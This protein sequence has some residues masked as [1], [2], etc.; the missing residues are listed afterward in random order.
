MRILFWSELF[1]PYIGGAEIWGM[2]FLRRL[3]Q[4]GHEVTVITSHDG[5]KLPD[6]TSYDGI[7]IYRFPFRKILRTG[8]LQQFRVTR[9]Q[10]ASLKRLVKPDLIH[11]NAVSASA[12]FHLQTA[13]ADRGSPWLIRI[14]QEIL[15]AD[16]TA[17]N[18]LLRRVLSTADWVTCVSAML[19]EQ[20]RKRA[21]EIVRRSSVIYSGLTVSCEGPRPLN[22]NQGALLCLG[23]LVPAKGFDL[24]L[25]ALAVAVRRFPRLRLIIAGDGPARLNLERRAVEL[26]LSKSVEFVGWVGPD[27]V[28][29]LLSNTSVVLM[30]SRR[31]GLPV[32]AIQAALAGK[33]IVAARVSGLPEA[34]IPGE[35]G[36]LIEKEDAQALAD[37]I[38]Y[39][40]ER[41][42][43]IVRMGQATRRRA[44]ELFS[45]EKCVDAYDALYRKLRER[46]THATTP[47]ST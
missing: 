29:N 45:E 41:P 24:A 31:E 9:Q 34:V 10:V 12:L 39:L 40:A 8:D 21:P 27:L 1:R 33:P 6:E 17:P 25:D 42:E 35:T 18:T 16:G 44:Q 36:L 32:V 11:V 20:V 23:R 46:N 14:N 4:R 15:S 37:A 30:P 19:L 43:T 38:C 7:A 3:I 13:D 28:T 22:I 47:I 2:S 26:G 5:I